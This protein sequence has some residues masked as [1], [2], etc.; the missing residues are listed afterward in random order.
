MICASQLKGRQF[1]TFP[2]TTTTSDWQPS[3][4]KAR[5][6]FVTEKKKYKKDA[7]PGK[8]SYVL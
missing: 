1:L 5:G 8:E 6:Y 3:K 7:F 4:G 2:V